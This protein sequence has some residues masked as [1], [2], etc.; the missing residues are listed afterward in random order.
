MSFALIVFL[1]AAGGTASVVG[2]GY[3]VGLPVELVS[4]WSLPLLTAVSGKWSTKAKGQLETSYRTMLV[5]AAMTL[6]LLEFVYEIF[7]ISLL[8]DSFLGMVVIASCVVESLSL[9]C[10]IWT[11][12]YAV[13]IVHHMDLE[14]NCFPKLMSA[15][16]QD[17][18]LNACR[19]DGAPD[20][21][22]GLMGVAVGGCNGRWL[23]QYDPNGGEDIKRGVAAFKIPDDH[24]DRDGCLLLQT[25]CLQE[26]EVVCLEGRHSWP[27]ELVV[28][29]AAMVPVI[30]RQ[31][32]AGPTDQV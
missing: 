16:L 9:I 29:C 10:I 14:Q 26:N 22:K 20:A 18:T 2:L 5:L 32:P 6:Y 1:E 7:A 28:F 8:G 19:L 21:R 15:R 30:N 31:H 25:N 4:L 13:H 3:T 17:G 23:E 12:L 24:E 11:I 27:C